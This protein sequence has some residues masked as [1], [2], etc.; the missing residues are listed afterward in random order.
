[1]INS[2]ILNAFQA[3]SFMFFIAINIIFLT[4]FFFKSL[5]KAGIPPQVQTIFLI[6]AILNLVYKIIETYYAQAHWSIKAGYLIT[7]L[8]INTT[9]ISHINDNNL[10]AMWFYII[11]PINMPKQFWPLFRNSII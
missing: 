10:Q 8:A 9:L 2:K 5:F 6:L 3:I 11:I 4:K 1:M 7:L